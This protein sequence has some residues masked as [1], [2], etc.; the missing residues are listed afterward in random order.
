MISGRKEWAG[1]EKWIG[2]GGGGRGMCVRFFWGNMKKRGNLEYSGTIG[3]IISKWVLNEQDR[4]SCTDFMWFRT[5][6][7]GKPL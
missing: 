1:Y 5:G 4:R 2:G 3:T 6:T 7:N